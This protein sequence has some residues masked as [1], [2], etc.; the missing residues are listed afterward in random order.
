MKKSALLVWLILLIAL[1][2]SLLAQTKTITGKIVDGKGDPVPLA[3]VQQ[4]GTNN[5]VTSNGQGTFSITL[6][7]KNP[8]LMVSSVGY[9]SQEVNTS[10]ESVVSITLKQGANQ[11]SEVVVTA[12]GITRQK[13]SLGYAAQS[14][15]AQQITESH[16]SNLLNAL[17]GKV[18]GVTIS[19]A[20]GGPGQ[21]AS[22]LIRG[23]NSL[24]PGKN[25]QPL[26]VID[27]LP[28]DNSTFTTGTSG[29][30]GVQMP[31]RVSDINPADIE[32]VN[33][34][35]G[36]A[37]TALYGLRGSNGVV[38]ITT[39]SGQAGKLRVNLSSSYSTDKV[40]KYPE[41]QLK[42][43]QGYTGI[44]DSTDFW[45]AWGPTVEK[46][47][48]VDPTHPATLE[49]TWKQAYNTG[50]QYNES[51]SFAGGT[52]KATFSSAL[53]YAK[54]DGLI[55]FTWY[56]DVTAR[57]SGQLKFS[58]KFKM[59]TNLYYANTD[60]NFYDADRYNEE[61]IYWAPRWDIRDYKKPDGTLKTYG[62][63]NPIY[64]AAT[65]KFRSQVDH[66]IGSVNFN[67]APVSWFNVNYMLGMDEY[68]DART[69]TA[70]GPQGLP[71]EIL[72]DD[73]GQGFVH[74]YRLNYRQ[75]NSNL[76][77]TFDH[78]WN[79]KFQTTFRIGND[80]LDRKLNRVSAEGDELDVYNL[81]NLGNAK[82]IAISQY[83]E[84]Y[85]IIGAYADLTL[86]YNNY[87]FLDITG[88]N[89]WT[90]TLEANN[91]SFFYPSASLS[92]VFTENLK[93]PEWLS[94]GKLRASLAKI[95]KDA[96]PYSTSIVYGPTTPPVNG[97]I[98]WGRGTQN[99]DGGRDIQAGISDL[100]PEQTT[101]VEVGT[102]LNF[103]NNRIG[104]N[105]TLYKSNSKDQIIPVSTAA[106]SGFTSIFL[107]AG[108]I[109]NKGLE[110]TLKG[111]PVKTKNF[112]W[113]ITL[114]YSANRNKIISIYPGLQEIVIGTQQGYSNSSVTMKYVPGQ[115]AGDLYGTPWTRYGDNKNPN[116]LHTDKSLPLLIGANGF[117]VLTPSSNQK[118]LGNSYP[119]WI[120]GIANN[121]TYKNWSL[122]MLWDTRQG[123]KKYNQFYNYLTAFGETPLTLN[124]EQTMVF[125]GVLA[126]GSKNTKPVFLGQGV[127]QMV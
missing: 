126:D 79:E 43:T 127:G 91:R 10:G 61:L 53:S 25:S 49:N 118:I 100:K 27:G 73:N 30:R 95:G 74:E 125:D 108:E 16:Q 71:G 55:P 87:L 123:V 48:Q 14:V 54:Q 122:Y 31:N 26:F 2:L 36:G 65:N 110:L 37:A 33:I 62:N 88:R 50:H 17:Q 89:D 46:A 102:D 121:F 112:N 12:L 23:V 57:V 22:I 77:L 97:V 58:D 107:N 70:P 96:D 38:V 86:G 3:T 117:P 92:Y 66:V 68:G 93:L 78:T 60:G 124:R 28:I 103:L 24:D 20:G 76:L 5:A 7:G 59:S 11:L 72:A 29:G 67:Y 35:R 84:N 45:P 101:S 32:N 114:N 111:T 85:R 80:V 4:K 34:L 119:K 116:S 41:Q 105:F 115:S 47:R 63:G 15:D 13:K 19:S 113:D 64:Y 40:N 39:K 56:Q 69:A 8:V 42:Y 21:G 75:L 52:D 120:A 18:A 44:Y 99:S 81:F 82:T 106:S 9:E 83:K 98:R 94:Y 1:P 51:V 6:S 109:E 90:S 104:F